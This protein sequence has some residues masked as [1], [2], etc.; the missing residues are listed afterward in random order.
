MQL[1]V[2]LVEP[3]EDL[4]YWMGRLVERSDGFILLA[5][6]SQV[7]ALEEIVERE[8]PE[9]I[10]LDFKAITGLDS[11]VISRL[12]SRL[13]APFLALTG[14]EDENS[15]EKLA[16]STGADGYFD[17]SHAP[18]SLLKIRQSILAHMGIGADEL[19]QS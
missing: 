17:N 16:L 12:K 19:M 9:L 7:D 15:Q 13:P 2:L 5:S 10:L 11:R 14:Y 4:R 6:C 18:Q 1:G 8:S 3:D